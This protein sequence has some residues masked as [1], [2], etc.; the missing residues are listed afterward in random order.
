MI[1]IT[2]RDRPAALSVMQTCLRL[3]AGHPA[4]TSWQRFWGADPLA[5]AARSWFKGALGERRIAAELAALGP[6][7][8]VLHALPVGRKGTDI[9]HLVIG[10]TGVFSINTKNHSGKDVWVGGSDFRVSG[11]RTDH[12]RNA[13]SEGRRATRNLSVA[14]GTSVLVQPLIVVSAQRVRFGRK[15][16]TVVVLR[17]GDV[18]R[19]ITGLP[20]AFSD[21]A[22]RY[23]AMVAE[24]PET[25]GADAAIFH[26][27]TWT[28]EGFS[29]LERDVREAGARRRKMLGM[30]LVA[31]VLAPPAAIFA[32]SALLAAAASSL[33]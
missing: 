25:W 27:A 12:M 18:V 2:L 10:P 1:P 9:D 20:R 30:S 33:S 32:L 28:V 8:T 16:P 22:V 7:F 29:S 23:H 6:S 15:R 24:E 11:G 21:E 14:A 19:W 3:Q 5:P 31:L 17:S 26:D 13:L 4:R